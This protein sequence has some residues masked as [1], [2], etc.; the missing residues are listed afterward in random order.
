MLGRNPT[1]ILREFARAAS[2]PPDGPADAELLGRFVQNK[3][4][5][6]FALLVRRRGPMIIGPAI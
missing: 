6:A 3:N 5:D 4:Q 1:T 2:V